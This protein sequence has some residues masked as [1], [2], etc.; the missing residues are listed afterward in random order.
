MVGSVAGCAEQT[1]QQTV[2][3][4]PDTLACLAAQ[5][6]PS[7]IA[8]CTRRWERELQRSMC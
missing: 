3:Q 5:R 8:L 4:Q 2:K 7:E 6:R 1:A